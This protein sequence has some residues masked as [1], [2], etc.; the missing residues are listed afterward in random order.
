MSDQSLDET[1]AELQARLALLIVQLERLEQSCTTWGTRWKAKAGR[2][3]KTLEDLRAL[4]ANIAQMPE[5]DLDN[6]QA[7]FEDATLCYQAMVRESPFSGWTAAAVGLALVAW[8]LALADVMVFNYMYIKGDETLYTVVYCICG[9]GLGGAAGALRDF[10]YYSGKRLYDPAWGQSYLLR[11]VL[12]ALMGVVAYALLRAGLLIASQGD[13]K[14]V[15]SAAYVFFTIAFV[16]GFAVEQ[17]ARKLYD[18]AETTFAVSDRGK[19]K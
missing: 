19:P 2:I 13:L 14:A 4:G 5:A 18:I 10:I 1:R 12:G 17:M 11:P 7:T 16:G 9:G 3:D 15:E 6:A 8:V